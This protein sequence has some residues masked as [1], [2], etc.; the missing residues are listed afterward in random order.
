[1]M[2]DVFRRPL[3]VLR[4]GYGGY[5]DVNGLHLWV[6]G[7]ADSFTIKASIQGADNEVLQ[8]LPEGDRMKEVYVLYTST[9][10]KTVTAA[11]ANADTVIINDREFQVIKVTARQNLSTYAT[12]HY[13]VVVVGKLTGS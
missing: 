9:E 5:Q 3:T 4:T 8:T 10:L 7:E 2:H 13:E 6:D 11:V 12:A 1:M